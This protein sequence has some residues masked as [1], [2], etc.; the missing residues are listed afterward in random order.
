MSE[1]ERNS[2]PGNEADTWT[3]L[4][5]KA[6]KI[7]YQ[8]MKFPWGMPGHVAPAAYLLSG[9]HVPPLLPISSVFCW[10]ITK[11]FLLFLTCA[12]L[13]FALIYGMAKS[14]CISNCSALIKIIS[15]HA[16]INLGSFSTCSCFAVSEELNLSDTHRYIAHYEWPSQHGTYSKHD[17]CVL[18][19]IWQPHTEERL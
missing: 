15:L 17:W 11:S 16:W 1:D 18:H 9:S 3:H 13:I 2:S 5:P 19:Q 12:C 14:N 4:M 8:N 6:L 7:Q 10:T